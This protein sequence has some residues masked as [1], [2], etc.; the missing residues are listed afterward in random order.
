[1]KR[2]AKTAAWLVWTDVIENCDQI[3]HRSRGER[4]WRREKEKAVE[5]LGL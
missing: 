3:E 1:M 2:R 5:K 4:I